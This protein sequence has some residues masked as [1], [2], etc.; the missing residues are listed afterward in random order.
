MTSSEGERFSY[1]RVGAG[2]NRFPA[3]YGPCGLA[4]ADSDSCGSK[5]SNHSKK[6]KRQQKTPNI[7]YVCQKADLETRTGC[8]RKIMRNLESSRKLALI[9]GNDRD[10]LCPPR[11]ASLYEGGL[12]VVLSLQNK[13]DRKQLCIW[14][15]ENHGSSFFTECSPHSTLGPRFCSCPWGEAQVHFVLELITDQETNICSL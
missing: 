10:N 6:I 1:S 12:L 15:S 5:G 7:K 2:G 8:F 3:R 11:C 13:D 14:F 9:S 4:V